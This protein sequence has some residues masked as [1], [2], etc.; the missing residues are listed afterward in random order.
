ME[1]FLENF[2]AIFVDGALLDDLITEGMILPLSVTF[3]FIPLFLGLLFYK[4]FDSVTYSEIKHW[5]L[6]C[7]ISGTFTFVCTL[8]TCIGLQNKEILRENI[9]LDAI[10][11][12]QFLFDQ[13]IGVFSVFAIQ[14]FILSLL[15]LLFFSLILKRFST[16]N[17]RNPFYF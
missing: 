5:V 10:Q 15:L 4:V 6:V 13:G 9:D 1:N 14:T 16:N 3:L 8:V 17:R 11:D 2:Y 12:D 7:I